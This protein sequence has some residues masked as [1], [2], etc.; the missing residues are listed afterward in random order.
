[1]QEVAVILPLNEIQIRP[2]PNEV[3]LVM[4]WWRRDRGKESKEKEGRSEI[5]PRHIPFAIEKVTSRGMQ[6]TT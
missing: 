2:N 5:I 6:G 3:S 4:N 1:M